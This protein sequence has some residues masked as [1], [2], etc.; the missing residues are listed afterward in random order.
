M[1][2]QPYYIHF[3]RNITS[4]L[5]GGQI[6]TTDL[7]G[8]AFLFQE[9]DEKIFSLKRTLG[10]I[11]E[12]EPKHLAQIDRRNPVYDISEASFPKGS[13]ESKIEILKP[14]YTDTELQDIV[15]D[16]NLATAKVF[17]DGLDQSF[18]NWLMLSEAGG[19]S[20]PKEAEIAVVIK[21][22]TELNS[23][24]SAFNVTPTDAQ[25][26]QLYAI[27]D[28]FVK[29]MEALKASDAPSKSKIAVFWQDMMVVYSAMTAVSYPVSEYLNTQISE[30]YLNISTAKNIQELLRQFASILKDF[31]LPRWDDGSLTSE[32]INGAEYNARQSGMIQSYLTL[33]GVLRMLTANLP[34]GLEASYSPELSDQIFGFFSDLN[35]IPIRHGGAVFPALRL[36][37]FI[38]LQYIYQACATLYGESAS[39]PTEAEYKAAL[40]KEKEY[41]SI[42][43][44]AGFNVTNDTFFDDYTNNL[45]Y[46]TTTDGG[47]S[48]FESFRL[49]FFN[50]RFFHFIMNLLPETPLIMSRAAYQHVLNSANAAISR[51]D[52]L[53]TNWTT[54]ITT[55]QTQ[56]AT[57][58]SSQL[59]Y[60]TSM[61]T[62]KGTFVTTSPLQSTY[63][64]IMLDKFLPAQQH[65]LSSLGAQM[66]FSNKTAKYL[67][68]LIHFIPSFHNAET[69]YSLSLYLNQMNLQEIKDA[70]GKA[71]AVLNDEKIRCRTDI[72]RCQLV[73]AEIDKIITSVKS[74]T[75]LTSS[76]IREVVEML[77]TYKSQ[78]N[79]LIRNVSQ[80]LVYLMGMT[81]TTV[82]EPESTDKAFDVIVYNQPEQSWKRQL[83]TFESFVIEGGQNAVIPGGEKQ[84][85]QALESSQQDYTT[86]N[87]NQQLALQL[88]M[89][90][91]QQE[92][93][94]V[95]T[96]MALL[97]QMFAKLAR[98]IRS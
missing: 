50:P 9:L 4:A 1:A 46:A 86:F 62:N 52:G 38:G 16:P 87:Q 13:P 8:A 37:A 96:A 41:W 63:T 61:N 2:I 55:K 15:N 44:N 31:L 29:E 49:N 90:A 66:T 48:I 25:Y 18:S 80:V 85:L 78:F 74:D 89:A 69:Y 45:F 65:I 59:K 7:V 92:W 77:T 93:T 82:P 23:L 95:S 73:Q 64:S 19:V 32:R 81:I 27:A 51:I 54:E 12:I 6:D 14:S 76:Q 34:Q 58:D 91:M 70:E 21:Y 24:K 53:I 35:G 83:A 30:L 94:V 97:N 79:D 28:N 75:D 57:I 39:N 10:W 43:G 47:A 72:K 20:D 5:A 88:E 84:I 36:D 3:T 42:R 68:Q 33:G 40:R 11:E 60:F 67:N 56:K 26:T 71:I 17:I 98:R 22:K